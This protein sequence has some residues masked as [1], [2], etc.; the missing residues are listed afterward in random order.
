[1]SVPIKR[2]VEAIPG[3]MMIVPLLL[4]AVVV[5][6]FPNAG[7]FFGSFTGGLFKGS[8]A[9]LAVF[10]VCMGATID[11]RTTPLVV[12]KGGVLLLAKV[13]VAA[14]VGVVLGQVL[15]EAP[16]GGG[17]LAGL[18]TLAVVAAMN[19]TNGGLYM[20]LM[21][22]FGRP[23]EAAAY[24]VMSLESGPFLTMLTL[25]V[26]GLSGFPWQTFV[27]AVLPLAVGML[28]GNLD[29]DL[30]EWFGRATAVLIPFFSFAL[31]CGINL[32]KVW[33]AGLLGVLL[34]VFVVLV[35][36]GVLLLADRLNGGTG[37]AGL[38]AA[39]TAGNAVAVPPVVAAANPAYA[40]A[41]QQ[42][43]ALVAASVVVTA[44][45]VPI[46]TAWWSRR[47]QQRSTRDS[48]TAEERA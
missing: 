41:A 13:A 45:L 26:A 43:T 22:Q 36:G 2:R 31:G 25:G 37:V 32:T 27:G 10:Y 3:G 38:A 19:D 21:A 44:I 5:T 40:P 42:A 4:G 48:G 35:S 30:R 24:S 14:L 8:M 46:A 23:S 28:L 17:V 7:S 11:V 9:I 1:M 34:G 12:R 6:L 16:I 39:S 29:P 47:V 33:K 15:G 18:S 20:A